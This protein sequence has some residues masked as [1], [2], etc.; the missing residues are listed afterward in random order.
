MAGSAAI[1]AGNQHLATYAR[2]FNPCVTLLPSVVDTEL[3]DSSVMS[4]PLQ[5][6]CGLLTQA[7]LSAGS[8]RL[9]VCGD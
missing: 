5:T 2:R 6:I 8:K 9:M 7:P 3:S 4:E 1:M